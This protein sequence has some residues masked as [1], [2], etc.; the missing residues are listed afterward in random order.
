MSMLNI[1]NLSVRYDGA[2]I[3]NDLSLTLEDDEILCLLGASGSGKTTLLKSIA[4]L[5]ELEGGS[6]TLGGRCIDRL[7]IEKRGI[8]MIFQDYA[9]FPHLDV[10]AN[11]GFGLR[12]TPQE[13][14]AR[15]AELSRMVRL[16]AFLG[17]YPHEL[18]GG[19]QQ[20]VAIVRALAC[21]PEC[22]LLD[23][24]FSNIDTQVRAELIAEM[25]R[26]LKKNGIPAVFVT[27]SNEEA[28]LFADRLALLEGGRLLQCGPADE[29][30][31]RPV[32][33][34]VADFM[35]RAN[36][37]EGPESLAL[38]PQGGGALLMARPEEL[39]LEEAAGT[40]PSSG[41]RLER[42]VLDSRFQGGHYL[43]EVSSAGGGV[44]FVETDRAF[45]PGECVLLS[46]LP[47]RGTGFGEEG[48][49]LRR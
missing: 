35:G 16:E 49:S 24:P 2:V 45:R 12:M 36:Y 33:R 17:R 8:G 40:S 43:T 19:Q 44:E 39:V 1:E 48:A 10:A 5:V 46:L 23:E 31:R 28:Y 11:I 47:G 9:L 37:F 14:K 20:R 30:Y 7:P 42:T 15:V 32:N 4:G 29:L 18:S 26:L 22:L 41:G 27:H 25:R 38:R 21:W 6:V 34:F 3:L 13:K